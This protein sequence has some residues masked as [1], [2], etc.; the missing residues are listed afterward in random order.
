MP[1][2][3]T[4]SAMLAGL[5]RLRLTPPPSCCLRLMSLAWFAGAVPAFL[6]ASPGCAAVRPQHPA[7]WADFTT[8]KACALTYLKGIARADAGTAKAACV[9]AD[10]Q[11]KSVDALV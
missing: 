3:I 4:T 6:M 7:A 5:R 9:G 10:E 8:P 1:K 11:K 2:R